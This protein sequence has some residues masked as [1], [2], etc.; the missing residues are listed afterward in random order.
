MTEGLRI[1]LGCGTCYLRG[2]ENVEPQDTGAL[3]AADNKDRVEFWATTEDNYYGRVDQIREQQEHKC[4]ALRHHLLNPFRDK[5]VCDRH[6]SWERIP[7]PDGSA[8][9]ILS[10]Q[11]FEHLSERESVQALQEARRVL[12]VGG[13]LRLDV[14]DHDEALRQYCDLRTAGET[15]KAEF[16]LSH[17]LGSRRN[18]WARHMGSW[19]R[20]RLKAV[21]KQFGF[22]FV[23]E[24]PN[25]HFYPAFC[26]RWKKIEHNPADHH[27]VHNLYE[28][29]KRWRASF[30]YC[31][32]PIGT[33]L[34]VPDNWKCLEVGPGTEPWPRANYYCDVVDR[35]SI[36]PPM[37]FCKGDVQNLP[38]ADKS[39]D[40][41]LASH[42]LEHVE[43]PR[44]AA[45]E[46]SRVARCGVVICPSPFKEALFNHHE[47]DHK[48]F[49]LPPGKSGAL[50]FIPIDGSFIGKMLD[51]CGDGSGIG[52]DFS[53][54]MHQF[55]RLPNLALREYGDIGRKWFENAEPWLDTIMRWE[56][57]LRVEILD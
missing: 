10:R 7:Y 52:N 41:V 42:V 29:S 56:G 17:I 44:K 3:L 21:V 18:S 27:P 47:A 31:G 25:I 12:K 33:P 37:S 6:G 55:L 26:L 30:D 4:E 15:E 45:A 39:M 8:A 23:A 5:L 48:W 16:M 51:P 22:E 43:D 57:N 20:E 54:V 38:Y 34:V 19:T 1:H 53:S 13:I 40:R 36:V 35:T 28:P 46:L 2:Y 9:E 14:P 50:R 32:D 11:V 49:V 24:E